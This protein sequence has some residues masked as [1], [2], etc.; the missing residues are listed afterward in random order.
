MLRPAQTQRLL[1]LAWR[2]SVGPTVAVESVVAFVAGAVAV[3][4]AVAVFVVAFA[5]VVA[6]AVVAAVAAT[7]ATAVAVV[8]IAF[9]A[10]VVVAD[11]A[12]DGKGK[13]CCWTM[14]QIRSFRAIVAA[15][16]CQV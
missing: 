3:V 15:L 4:D 1:M 6:V 12:I 16:A 14:S 9:A 10:D 2:P 11:V 8:G 7:V 5:V 13:C